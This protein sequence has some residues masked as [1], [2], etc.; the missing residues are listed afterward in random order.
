MIGSLVKVTGLANISEPPKEAID[1]FNSKAVKPSFDYRDVW[2]DAHKSAFAIAKMM[3]DDLLLMMQKTLSET[4]TK[5]LPVDEWK[6][7]VTSKLQ[8]A[9]WWGKG[10]VVDPKTG[11]MSIAQLG[12]PARLDMIFET[13]MRTAY[14]AG[15]WER[16]ERTKKGL[17]YLEYVLGP[18]EV[19]RPDHVAWNGTILPVDH[20]WWATHAPPNGYGCKCGVRQLTRA[21]AER[22]GVSPDPVEELVPWLNK[23]TG[24]TIKVPKGIDPGWDTKP[25]TTLA[26]PMPP[27]PPAPKAKRT[28]KT[29]APV[30]PAAPVVANKAEPFNRV[31]MANAIRRHDQQEMR[32]QMNNLLATWGMRCSDAERGKQHAGLI[33]IEQVPQVGVAGVYNNATGSITISKKSADA[34]IVQLQKKTDSFHGRGFGTFI[35]EAV[36]S[37]ANRSLK[38]LQ[39]VLVIE[40]ATTEMISLHIAKSMSSIPE[41]FTTGSGVYQNYRGKLNDIMRTEYKKNGVSISEMEA[42]RQW[43]EASIAMRDGRDIRSV[44]SYI[45]YLVEGLR[46]TGGV[47]V[48]KFTEGITKGL[49]GV[50]K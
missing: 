49:W 10:Q 21:E 50:T 9:G 28:K 12:S 14:A 22:R 24:E 19:H 6:K 33:A 2:R 15:Q 30:A 46:P 43:A 35:H 11:L 25:R 32:R 4:I 18:S 40:E 27:A 3:D 29:A 8:A 16:I 38:I 5:G 48:K 47:D 34:A 41:L 42:E 26:A 1:F 44:E 20:P 45:K 36:H 7:L 37:A 23:R 17:P 39:A 13:N 31:A